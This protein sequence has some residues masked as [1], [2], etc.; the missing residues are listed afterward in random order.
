MA[1]PQTKKDL[2]EQ[3]VK[4]LNK[5]MEFI[6]QL[7]E[8]EQRQEFPEGTMNRNI[9]DVLA[10]LHRWHLMVLDWYKVGMKGDT[11]DIPAKGYNWRQLPKL[12]REIWEKYSSTDL[13]QVEEMFEQSHDSIMKVVEKHS[14]DELFE[15]GR[16]KWTGNNALGAYLVSCTASHYDW[17]LKLIRK[18]RKGMA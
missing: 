11:P 14:N 3:A 16:Y 6:Q 12:N 4:N 17:A 5:L 15:R 1:R 9:R 2:Q 10:H 18:A 7:S 8:E 13:K